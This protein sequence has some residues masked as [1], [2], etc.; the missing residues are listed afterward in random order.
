MGI[1]LYLFILYTKMAFYVEFK[2]VKYNDDDVKPDGYHIVINI[3]PTD[4]EKSMFDN[5]LSDV[6]KLINDNEKLPS[7]KET[8]IR[9]KMLYLLIIN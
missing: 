1:L 6:G 4:D 3:N 5:F 2:S 7:D 9:E 8:T